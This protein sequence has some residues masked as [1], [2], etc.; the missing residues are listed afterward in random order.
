MIKNE[1]IREILRRDDVRKLRRESLFRWIEMRDSRHSVLLGL[2]LVALAV[3]NLWAFHHYRTV[4]E[5]SI[6]PES[7]ELTIGQKIILK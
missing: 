2:L 1:H 4:R 7:S 6:L 5:E 3:A